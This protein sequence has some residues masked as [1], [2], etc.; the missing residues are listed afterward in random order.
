[1]AGAALALAIMLVPAILA[2][3]AQA[4]TY[5]YSLLYSFTGPPDGAR[6]TGGVPD[7][8]GNLYGT[9]GYGGDS[10]C[11][12]PYGC[13]TVFKLSPEPSGGCPS[14]S[15]VGT[16]WCETVLYSFTGTGGD[17]EGPVGGLVLDAKGNLY[18]TTEYGGDLSCNAPDGCGTVFKFDTTTGKETVLYSFTGSPDASQPHGGLV[19]DAQG[20][21]Y[22][23]TPDVGAY[24]YGAVYEVDTADKETVLYSFTGGADGGN[25]TEKLVRDAQGN[26][27]GTTFDN[28]GAYGGTV[29]KLSPEPSGGCPSGSNVGTGWCETVLYSFTGT[30]GGSPQGDLIRDAHGNLYGAT[31]FGGDLTCDAP[32]G[33]GTVFMLAPPAAPSVTWTETVLYNWE[34]VNEDGNSGGVSVRDAQG[35]LYGIAAGGGDLACNAPNGCGT[36]VKLAP[37]VSPSG[38]WTETVLYT[39]TKEADGYGPGGLILDAQGTLYGGTGAGGDLACTTGTALIGCGTVFKLTPPTKTTTTL[40]SSLNPSTYGQAVTFTAAVTSKLGAPPD[41]ETVSF[42]EGKTVL[43]TGTLSGGSASFTTSTLK[44]GTNSITAVYAGDSN[45]ASSKSKAVKQV[46]GKATTATTLASSL[47]PSNVGQSVTFTASVAPEFSGTV[48]GK[49]AFYD[50]TTLLKTVALSG[51]EAEFTTSTLTSGTHT[52]TATYNGSTSFDGSTSAP[53]SQTVD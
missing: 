49:V 10:A 15:N 43:G 29:F 19:E 11:D 14:G 7:A 28:N 27:Y 41:G 26:L 21:L 38:L 53:L 20:N 37:P 52:I 39:F 18:G 6:L 17:G 5:S 3:S 36:V 47:N 31:K 13:G 40:T 30:E 35:N 22:G 45:F 42:M 51:S 24:G 1:M 2:G 44:V 8:H 34:D 46:V 9:T 12:P 32:N 23:T 33:C 25:P 16:G 50:G 48:I 4:Q